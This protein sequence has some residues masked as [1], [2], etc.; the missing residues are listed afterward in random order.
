MGRR[1]VFAAQV[2]V[3]KHYFILCKTNKERPLSLLPGSHR[4][5]NIPVYYIRIQ[6]YT[7][8][9]DGDD[10]RAHSIPCGPSSSASSTVPEDALILYGI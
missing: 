6:A 9:A 8:P 3:Y 7:W 10:F 4:R 2:R 5:A 1:L